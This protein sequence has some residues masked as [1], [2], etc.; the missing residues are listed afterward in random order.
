M[1]RISAQRL[2]GLDFGLGTLISA[3]LGR[4]MAR[5]LGSRLSGSEARILKW[6]W[7]GISAQWLDG[8]ARSQLIKIESK[9]VSCSNLGL[10]SAGRATRVKP[11]V[12]DRVGLTWRVANDGGRVRR[13]NR[14]VARFI[15]ARNVGGAWRRV[16]RWISSV[17]AA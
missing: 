5:W 10:T 15:A 14:L 2:G 16:H 13:V 7:L 8:L 9:T 4:I 17:F 1:A 3:W 6:S 12:S 11:R